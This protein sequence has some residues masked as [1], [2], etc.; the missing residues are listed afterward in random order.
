[1]YLKI[2]YFRYVSKC[3][4]HRYIWSTKHKRNHVQ[5][6]YEKERHIVR[7]AFLKLNDSTSSLNAYWIT[8]YQCSNY[9]HNDK[10]A[11][12]KFHVIAWHER[13][14]IDT[15][16]RLYLEFIIL[17]IRLCFVIQMKCAN[18]NLVN[19]PSIEMNSDVGH[20]IYIFFLLLLSEPCLIYII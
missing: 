17:S 3:L 15:D 18:K 13:S 16:L 1:M 10:C 14:C 19:V 12:E 4:F 5:Q 2:R 8:S 11:T 20:A 9:R 6:M 7:H